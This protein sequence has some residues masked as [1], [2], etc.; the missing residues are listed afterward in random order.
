MIIE[1]TSWKGRKARC[2]VR[3]SLGMTERNHGITVQG[4]RCSTF[5]RPG[6]PVTIALALTMLLTACSG[7]DDA[8]SDDAS[9][10]PEVSVIDAA[11]DTL[12]AGDVSDLVVPLDYLQGEWCNSDGEAWVFEGETARFGENHDELLGELPVGVALAAGSERVLILQSDDEFVVDL[13]TR[14]LTFTRGRC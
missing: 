8:S 14:E 13:Q 11:D 10:Q 1:G 4:M 5:H 6:R 12:P 9:P 2:L 7:G 3:L